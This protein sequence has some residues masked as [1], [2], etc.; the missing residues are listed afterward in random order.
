MQLTHHLEL[1]SDNIWNRLDNANR[2]GINQ[3]EETLTDNLLLYLASQNLPSIHIVQTPKNQEAIKGTDW[4]WWIGSKKRGF[5]RYAVQAKKLNLKTNTYSSL[6]QKVGN[7]SSAPYQHDV[8]EKYAQLNNAIPLYAFYN[9]L[10]PMNQPS[11]WN[12]PLSFD[13]SQMG[14][15]V[16]PL[17]NVKRAISKRGYRTFDKIHQFPETIPLRCLAK[18][19]HINS[20]INSIQP[21]NTVHLSKFGLEAKIYD[22]PW[23]W[24]SEMGHLSSCR[25][26]P[27]DFYNHEQGLYPKHILYIDIDSRA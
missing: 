25:Q 22:D 15:T 8:L 19:P 12:C 14:C 26:M 24:I 7:Q 10:Q 16:T 2:F 18:C 17:K 23:G 6:K 9:Y 13:L 20:Q 11:S 27:S 21:Q 1:V 5:L 4:E 3:G